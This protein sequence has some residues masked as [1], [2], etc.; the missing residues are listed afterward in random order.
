M[1]L[2]NVKEFDEI[3]S[4]QGQRS[5]DAIAVVEV[6]AIVS[7]DYNGCNDCNDLMTWI[8]WIYRHLNVWTSKGMDI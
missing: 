8:T 6:V 1:S 2:Q 7:K 5:I 3:Y 4:K